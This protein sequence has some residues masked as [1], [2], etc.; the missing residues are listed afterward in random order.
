MNEFWQTLISRRS[1]LMSAIWQ[2][3]QISLVSLLIAMAI[4]IP[5]ALLVVHHHRAANV[6]TQITGVFQTIP[7]LAL[8]GLLI[9]I[10]GIGTV[11]AVIALVV[12]ALLPIFTGTLT[13]ITGI[14]PSLEEAADAFGMTRTEKLIRVEFPLAMPTLIAGIRQALVMIIGTATLAALIGA[15]GL[16]DFILLGIDRN[17][18]SMTLIGAIASALLAIVFSGIIFILQKSKLR[19]AVATLALIILVPSGVGLYHAVQPAP[20]TITIAGKMGSEPDILINMYKDMIHQVDPRDKVILKPN[21]GQT[22]FLFN[23]L[24]SQQID[25]YPEFTG[26]VLESLVK[27]TKNQK[28]IGTPPA[29]LYQYAKND[30]SQQFHMT[31]L[32]PMAYNNTYAVVIK[33]SYADAHNIKTIADLQKVEGNLLGGF[34]LEFLDRTDGY[35]GLQSKYGL[36]FKTQSMDPDL[37]YEAINSG[38]INLTDGYSTDSQIRQY[39]LVALQDNRQLFPT[40]QG[41]P[42]MNTTFANKNP[43]IIAALN[44]LAGHISERD[45]QEMNYEVNVKQQSAASVAKH[46]LTTHHLLGGAR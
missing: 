23:A 4:G 22:A 19:Y 40:Y 31:Y 10:V 8:L 24:K 9:P 32:K 11:P 41:A 25:I 7:S 3:I 16:G 1:D 44:K 43:K 6:L 2:H 36:N 14:D 21:F 42:L 35:K 37:R 29:Q 45:M 38:K 12:Y 34:D 39:R 46:Y 33:K 18:N 20:Q 15:G 27:P 26:T 5:L 30:L 13:G 28:E 17:N